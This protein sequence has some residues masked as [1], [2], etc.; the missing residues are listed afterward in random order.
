MGQLRRSL[1]IAA[2]LAVSGLALLAPA[3][4]AAPSQQ[5]EVS[6]TPALYPAFSTSTF[7]YVVRCDGNPVRVHVVTPPNVKVSVDGQSLRKGTF[8]AQVAV[9][10][11]QEFTVVARASGQSSTTYYVRCL[12]TDFP[13]FSAQRSGTPQAAFYVTAPTLGGPGSPYVAIFDNHGAPVWWAKSPAQPV[14]ATFL[15]DGN[16]AWAQFGAQIP[17]DFGERT[18]SGSL[19]RTIHGQGGVTNFHDLQQVPG[20]DYLIAQTVHRQVDTTPCGGSSSQDVVAHDIQQVH[21]DNSLVWHWD[22]AAHIPASEVDPLWYDQ[23]RGG[24]PYHWNAVERDGGSVLVSYRHLNAIYKVDIASGDIVW[25]LGGTPTA[26]SLTIVGDPDNGFS[27]QHDVRA[28]GDGT[29][30]LHDNESR[31]SFSPR[32]VRYRIDEGART[33][34]LVEQV[35]HPDV[36]SSGCCGSARR[37]PGGDWVMGWGADPVVT[38][39]TAAGETRFKLTFANGVFSYRTQ[40]LTSS[41]VGIGALRAGMNSQFP[42]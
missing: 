10:N 20:G 17:G 35:S 1:Q 22:T 28:L 18:L 42:R 36:P 8:D 19:V 11:G 38:E 13:G 23:C 5:L 33:A 34:T 30:T 9:T 16:I 32:A 4:A 21:P 6:T 29:I 14:D 27:G 15:P 12:P 40:P 41:A 3:A 25:K 26:K 37:L 24:D 39:Q 2:A 7:D 31:R